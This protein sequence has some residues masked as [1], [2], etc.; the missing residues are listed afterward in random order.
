MLL[1]AP[2]NSLWKRLSRRDPLAIEAA[3]LDA[4]GF[5]ASC[6]ELPVPEG[7]DDRPYPAELNDLFSL[8]ISKEYSAAEAKLKSLERTL[9]DSCHF[10]QKKA[11]LYA[12][13]NKD[14]LTYRTLQDGVKN[15]SVRSPLYLR[16]GT[17]ALAKG[18]L[19]ISVRYFVRSIVAAVHTG[20]PWEMAGPLYLA[21]LAS[22]LGLN[23]GPF[24]TLAQRIGSTPQVLGANAE[25]QLD[26]C[27][28]RNVA[29]QTLARRAI[30]ALQSRIYSQ[31]PGWFHELSRQLDSEWKRL[32]T[33]EQPMREVSDALEELKKN[34]EQLGE[35]IERLSGA[36]HVLK[37]IRLNDDGGDSECDLMLKYWDDPHSREPGNAILGL[38]IVGGRLQ[39]AADS[40]P[41]IRKGGSLALS[42]R[43]RI[44]V[45]NSGAVRLV[46][47]R[48]S[49]LE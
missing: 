20:G 2:M 6:L 8:I 31:T 16:L 5:V 30:E 9:F 35:R 28:S 48:K 1:R 32:I 38:D 42:K 15:A 14:R 4:Q 11:E 10:Y 22:R 46:Y 21:H 39:S 27:L 40:V 41:G 12:I 7:K 36:S 49:V 45:L 24:V 29:D 37:K 43:T 19:L 34:A 13:Q 33:E 18:Y 23:A 44:R 3:A 47:E 26:D 25:R 17:Y